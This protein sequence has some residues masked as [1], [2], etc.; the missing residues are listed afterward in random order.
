MG[1]HIPT[2]ELFELLIPASCKN[3]WLAMLKANFDDSGTHGSSEVVIVAGIMG[4]ESELRTLE[5]LW[6]EHLVRPL[7]GTKPPIQEFHAAECADSRGEF[8]GWK[9]TETDYFRHQL[10]EVIIKSHVSGYG[11]ACVR[12]D[13]DDEIQGDLRKVFGDPEGYAITNCFVRALRW[14]NNFTFDQE[15]SFVFDKKPERERQLPTPIF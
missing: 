13:W 10:R 2:R 14:A 7:C 8:A 5:N 9:R 15:I 4:T 12:K 11:F 1:A 6:R 3:G